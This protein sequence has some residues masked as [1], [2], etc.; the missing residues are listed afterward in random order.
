MDGQRGEDSIEELFRREGIDQ[1]HS[2]SSDQLARRTE[3]WHQVPEIYKRII[4]VAHKAIMADYVMATMVDNGRALAQMP[5][6][7]VN[8]YNWS[9]EKRA[10]FRAA[11]QTAWDD[12]GTRTPEAAAMVESRQTFLK[13]I[14]LS[15]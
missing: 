13:Q 8:V 5:E 12:W 14:G 9:P 11:A 6:K 7:V 4:E 15:E 10:K 3:V 1:L 2:M